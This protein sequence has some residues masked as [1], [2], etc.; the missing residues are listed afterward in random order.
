LDLGFLFFLKEEERIVG[1][2]LVG[3]GEFWASWKPGLFFLR[4]YSIQ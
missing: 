2:E 1:Y 4:R 3:D